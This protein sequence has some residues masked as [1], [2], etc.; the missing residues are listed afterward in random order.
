MR[1]SVY[2]DGFNLYYGL[3]SAGLRRFYW[4]DMARLASQIVQPGSTLGAVKYFTARTSGK[5]P[6]D[7]PAEALDR[8]QGQARQANYLAALKAVGGVDII[9][10]KY[11][12]KPRSCKSC[13]APYY[14]HEEK[15]TDVSIATELLKDAHLNLYDVA[16]LVSGDSDLS[17]AIRA[18]HQLFAG[19]KVI[20]AF[21]PDRPSGHLRRMTSTFTINRAHLAQSQLPNPVVSGVD[22]YRRPVEWTAGYTIPPST[23]AMKSEATH[24][25][26]E[27]FEGSCDGTWEHNHGV[28]IESLDNPGWQVEIDIVGTELEQRAYPEVAMGIDATGHPISSPWLHCQIRDGKWCGAGDTSQL[29]PIV[30]LFLEWAR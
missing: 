9:E 29:L 4:L 23:A 15:M 7:T 26:Q 30:S 16:I 5:L 18:V 20:V 24:R 17:P 6:L 28:T 27:W 1:V 11:Q 13:G 25:L 2:V 21:P 19:K 8:A 10:G 3:K 22:T 14:R 12:S